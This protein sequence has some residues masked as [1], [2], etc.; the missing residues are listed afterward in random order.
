LWGD[1]LYKLPIAH[2]AISVFVV[3]SHKGLQVL[4]GGCKAMVAEH[5]LKLVE[6]DVAIS[7]DIQIVKCSM[8]GELVCVAQPLAQILRHSLST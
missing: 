3:A 2:S 1:L 5:T 6:S 4:L 7:V 8:E